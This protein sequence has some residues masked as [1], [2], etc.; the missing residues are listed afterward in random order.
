VR[1]ASPSPTTAASSN[2]SEVLQMRVILDLQC[3]ETLL[4][5]RPHPSSGDLE[6]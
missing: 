1:A 3:G 4:F 5:G 6:W 2:P